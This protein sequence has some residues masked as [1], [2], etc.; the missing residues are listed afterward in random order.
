MANRCLSANTFMR[1]GSDSFSDFVVNEMFP[2]DAACRWDWS[3]MQ[4]EPCGQCRRASYSEMVNT[5]APMNIP[6][7][8]P[9]HQ[10]ALCSMPV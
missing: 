8:S 5:T 10:R 1:R 9:A 3:N 2:P 4:C 7:L 6:V